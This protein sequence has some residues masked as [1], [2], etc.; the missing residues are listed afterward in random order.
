MPGMNTLD[1]IKHPLFS[2][3]LDW[4]LLL[5]DKDVKW[6]DWYKTPLWRKWQDKQSGV[7]VVYQ[8]M[9]EMQDFESPEF[10]KMLKMMM[11]D[12]P[13]VHAYHTPEI[14]EMM[15]KVNLV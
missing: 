9:Y 5:Q 1:L 13:H 12:D 4:K 15:E 6:V 3:T 14:H 2:R 11:S 7:D 8:P 10:Q